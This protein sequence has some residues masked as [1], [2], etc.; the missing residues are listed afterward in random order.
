MCLNKSIYMFGAVFFAAASC[1]VGQTHNGVKAS[2]MVAFHSY[3]A[4]AATT[5]SNEMI[6]DGRVTALPTGWIQIPRGVKFVLT[7]VHFEVWDEEG[8]ATPTSFSA[9]LW[10]SFAED[11]V[12]SLPSS[13]KRSMSREVEPM[14]RGS[15]VLFYAPEVKYCP[16]AWAAAHDVKFQSGICF[17]SGSKL[18]GRLYGG[19]F[20]YDTWYF[21]YFTTE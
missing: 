10:G 5:T 4:T 14:T 11:A 3:K 13:V 21:G 19:R 1:L 2:Q 12:P 9:Y 6:Q 20:Y 15:R 8:T 7:D 16:N 18:Y 17:T